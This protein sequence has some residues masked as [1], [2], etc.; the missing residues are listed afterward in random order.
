MKAEAEVRRARLRV[1]VLVGAAI[2]LMIVFVGGI[3][4][5]VMTQAQQTQ[6][7]REL[8]YNARYGVPD[9]A[10]RCAW[11]F[12]LEN[13]VLDQ[14][15]LAVP[16]GFPLRPDLDAVVASGVP[17]ERS[18]AA[19]GTRYEVLTAPGADGTTVQAVFDLRY[20]LSDRWHLLL[21]LGIAQAA[22]LV[23]AALIGLGVSRRAIGPLAEAL[24]RQQR[25][26]TDA[27]HELRTPIARAHL[28]AQL[29]AA[30][31]PDAQRDN[32]DAL[33]RS[34]RGLADV[35]DDLL[36]SSQL[37]AWEGRPVD[38]ADVAEAAVVG[39]TE[40]AA[41]RRITLVLAHPGHPL[42]VS[43]VETAL[44]RAVDEL[45]AN[46]VRHTPEGGRISVGVAAADGFVELVVSDTGRGFDPR[47]ADGLFERFRGGS[48]GGS[49]GSGEHGGSGG[50]ARS[51]EHG[52]LGGHGGFG[53]GLALVREVVTGHGGSVEA[54]GRPGL[55]ARFT[56]RVP[57]AGRA[58]AEV[59]LGSGSPATHRTEL[60]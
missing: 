21:A 5:L 11:V 38:L 13:G 51:G 46:A 4:Y 59:P 6:V 18:V 12:T 55:G 39:E 23:V 27:S 26:V 49:G 10:P 47:E 34:I 2:T 33:A 3:A 40:R 57:L 16:A 7:T 56:L 28:R 41:Q 43:G 29:L 37:G 19:N 17:V 42:V 9:V 31:V 32:L 48:G 44:R 22:G 24:T 35:V 14:G 54:V 53:L 36:R 50:P 52:G 1:S 20:Q 58:G 30:T 45:L 60:V 8:Q 25:F 15:V